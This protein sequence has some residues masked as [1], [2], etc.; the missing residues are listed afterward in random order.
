MHIQRAY[1]KSAVK[2]ENYSLKI[3]FLKNTFLFCLNFKSTA[4]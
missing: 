4:I 2:V 3:L 1:N